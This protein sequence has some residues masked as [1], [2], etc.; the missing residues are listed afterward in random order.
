MF[1]CLVHFFLIFKSSPVSLPPKWS[2]TNTKEQPF[3]PFSLLSYPCLLKWAPLIEE[4]IIH[5]TPKE[6][7]LAATKCLLSNK[8]STKPVSQNSLIHCLNFWYLPKQPKETEQNKAQ[9][10]PL[11]N[12]RVL[13]VSFSHNLEFHTPFCQNVLLQIFWSLHLA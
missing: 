1:N 6:H 4:C 2:K 13:V 10:T 11:N 5:C 3:M 8:K 7:K 12:A 9:Q